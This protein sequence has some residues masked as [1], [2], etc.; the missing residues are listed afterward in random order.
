[1][2]TIISPSIFAGEIEI[3]NVSQA[4]IE[5]DV[6]DS[7]NR[8]EKEVLI[9]LLGYPLYKEL[10]AA[11]PVSGDKWDKLI[12]GDEFSFVLNSVTV[13]TKWEGL[14][15]LIA[16]YVYFKHRQKRASYEAG[17][18][19]EVEANTENSTK[20]SVYH[21]LVEIWNRF[22]DVYGPCGVV[23]YYVPVYYVNDLPSA[24]NYLLTKKADF[25]TW[26]YADMGGHLNRFG[27]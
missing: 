25:T 24:Y 6:Q 13:E 20:T 9:K 7:I 22:I 26:L 27:I 3:P 17:V 1:M 21:K 12:N 5:A 4:E 11:V 14:N 10:I 18:G 8:Y 15:Q 19:V 16:Y 2:A 23:M